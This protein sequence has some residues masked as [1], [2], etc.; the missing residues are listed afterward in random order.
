LEAVG[1]ETIAIYGRALLRG[2]VFH[3]TS[4]EEIFVLSNQRKSGGGKKK[5]L[6]ERLLE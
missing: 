6:K 1:G 2:A 5:C 3:F 4:R